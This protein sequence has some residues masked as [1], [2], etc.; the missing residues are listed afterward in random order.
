MIFDIDSDFVTNRT[1]IDCLKT[2][3]YKEDIKNIEIIPADDKH[4]LGLVSLPGGIIDR[5][6][7]YPIVYAFRLTP[8]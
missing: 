4:F 3:Y 5:P 6:D 1:I 7:D 2:K 8:D